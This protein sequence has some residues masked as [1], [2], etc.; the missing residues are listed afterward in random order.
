MMSVASSVW[1]PNHVTCSETDFADARSHRQAIER[2]VPP[3]VYDRSKPF[4]PALFISHRPSACI[5]FPASFERARKRQLVPIRVGHVE[6]AFSPGS[7]SRTFRMKSLSPQICPACIHVRH[8]ENQASPPGR[9]F[10][11]FQILDWIRRVL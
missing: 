8:V 3:N 11:L 5:M 4:G 1:L 9:R 2:L 7:V 10:T 6:I